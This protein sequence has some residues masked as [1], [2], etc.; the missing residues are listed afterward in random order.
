MI[1]SE[2]FL[3]DL[4]A[5][6]LPAIGADSDGNAQFSRAL[7]PAEQTTATNILAGETAD[8]LSLRQRALRDARQAAQTINGIA[9]TDLTAGQQKILLALLTANEGWIAW[10]GSAW[11]VNVHQ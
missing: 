8:G 2:K 9:F 5:A 3:E 7:T 10:N 4:I 1:N 6:G 11:V